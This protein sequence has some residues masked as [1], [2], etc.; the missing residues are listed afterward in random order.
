MANASILKISERTRSAF[1]PIL[2]ALPS[3][4]EYLSPVKEV[5]GIGLGY[6]LRDHGAPIA[7]AVISVI[8]GTPPQQVNASTLANKFG[9]PI[10]I[11]DAEV[12]EQLTVQPQGGAMA[13]HGGARRSKLELMLSDEIIAAPLALV[14]PRVGKYELLTPSLL[15]PVAE[16]MKVTICVSPEAGWSELEKFLR[17][18][19]THLLVGMYQFTAPHIFDALKAAVSEPGRGLKLI[20]HPVPERPPTA[21]VKS[22]DRPEPELFDELKR[23]LADRFQLAWATIGKEGLWASAY[24]IKVAVRDGQALWASSGNWQSSNQPAVY[25]FLPNAELPKGFQR[26]YNRD[27][28]AIIENTTLARI[29]ETYLARDYEL[30]FTEG[31]PKE[32]SRPDLFVGEEPEE[33]VDFAMPPVFFPPLQLDRHVRVQPLLT[34]DNYAYAALELIRSAKKYVWFQNQYINFRDTGDDFEPFQNLVA[35]LKQ[36]IDEGREVRIICRDLMKQESVDILLA[37]DFPR[38]CMRFQ[39]ACHNKTIIVDGE[40]VMLGSHNWSNEG[41][42]SNRDSSLIFH[43]AEIAGYLAKI[44]EYDWERLANGKPTHSRPRVASPGEPTPPNMRRARHSEHHE[45]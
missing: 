36:K 41:V 35:A 18:V 19:Q 25:P 40:R 44:Y 9:V 23:L 22:K 1:A 32:E 13:F 16:Q 29:Y 21:G 28:H 17:G 37:L 10:T 12:E 43:D 42:V 2:K 24:H 45:D 30:A 38:D 27:Y 20:V 6:H 7:A 33:P 39:P 4:R 8:P 34:P 5:I 31:K 14:P 15:E 26:K 3:I 11:R